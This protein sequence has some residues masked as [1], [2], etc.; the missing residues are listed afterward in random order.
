MSKA[1]TLI[2][3]IFG[4]LLAEIC[5]Y[6]PLAKERPLRWTL[7]ANPTAGGFTI[8][9]RWKK[10]LRQLQECVLRAQKN[11]LHVDAFPS[12]TGLKEG[13]ENGLIP[14]RHGG[15]ARS[16]TEAL[17]D[18][19]GSY[20]D[21]YAKRPFN[22]II[23][24]GG[25]GTSLDVLT[26][27]YHMPTGLRSHFAVLR[28]PMGTGNDGADAWELEDAL[29]LLIDPAKP[30]YQ[31]ALR[32]TTSTPGKGPFL[33]FNILSVGLD[34]F[35]THMT[36]KTKGKMPGDTYKLW[37]DVASLLYDRLYKVGSM[38]VSAFDERGREVRSFS[39]KVLLLAVGES[40]HRTYG[41]HKKILPDDRNVCLV[42]QMPMLRKVALKGLFTTG[43]HILKP[44]S[45]VFNAHRVEFRGEEPLLA[46][47]DGETVLLQKRDFPAAIELTELVIP[48][49]KKV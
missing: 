46:Q 30:G 4:G 49:L 28:L 42:K 23:T 22:L 25:D 3:E 9:S 5:L 6:T 16:I 32:L 48:V 24:A 11:P 43:E 35:V 39:E 20:S 37:V 2:P 29:S 27:L 40:G 13:D 14:T 10:H 21:I 17:I 15:H 45:V 1:K 33:A 26:A 47:M 44:E 38:D 8:G 12:E 18:E 31:R 34:A 7:I 41:S 19:A 36:N